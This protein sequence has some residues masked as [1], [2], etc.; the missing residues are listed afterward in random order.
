MIAD[1]TNHVNC[2][3][4]GLRLNIQKYLAASQLETYVEVIYTAPNIE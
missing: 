2:F 1:E 4:Q 3:S